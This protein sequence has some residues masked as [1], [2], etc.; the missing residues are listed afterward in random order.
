MG[1]GSSTDEQQVGSKYRTPIR[2]RR[3][4]PAC[5]R[6]PGNWVQTPESS[7]EPEQLSEG[8]E[9][10]SLG[11]SDSEADDSPRRFPIYGYIDT[12]SEI[13]SRAVT[14]D[15]T[16]CD[17][18]SKLVETMSSSVRSLKAKL[19]DMRRVDGMPLPHPVPSP[20]KISMVGKWVDRSSICNKSTN[21]SAGF[22]SLHAAETERS[23]KPQ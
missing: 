4:S 13:S 18:P 2:R 14:P 1:C 12:R 15:G 8:D 19:S 9:N 11:N 21:L 16:E 10:Q 5:K 6:M 20:H 3:D 22:R 7:P 23:E 17:E